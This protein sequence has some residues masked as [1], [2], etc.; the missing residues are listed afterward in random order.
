[1]NDERTNEELVA[2]VRRD[3]SWLTDMIGGLN[4]QD[5]EDAL[6]ELVS[7]ADEGEKWRKAAEWLAREFRTTC[8][9]DHVCSHLID[10]GSCEG[11]HFNDLC[12][13]MDYAFHSAEEADE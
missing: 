3:L 2:V 11:C 9:R 6:A 4:T 10:T 13:L 1:M 8:Q 5:A 12:W 7:R